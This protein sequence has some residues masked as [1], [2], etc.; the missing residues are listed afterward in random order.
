MVGQLKNE[1]QKLIYKISKSVKE[2]TIIVIHNFIELV[3]KDSI[4]I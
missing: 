1:D 4:E 2:K 3:D